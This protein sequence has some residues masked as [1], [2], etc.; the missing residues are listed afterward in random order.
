MSRGAGGW[1]G[2]AEPRPRF[3]E[4]ELSQRRP[5]AGVG[6]VDR[7]GRLVHDRHP[8]QV[9]H[10]RREWLAPRVAGRHAVP[11]GAPTR[12]GRAHVQR[13]DSRPPRAAGLPLGSGMV[14]RLLAIPPARRQLLMDLK[15]TLVIAPHP[16]DESIAA[17]GLLQR[18][19]AGG[20]DVH[21]IVVT[22]GDN[23]PWPLRYLKKKV[24]VTDADRAEWGALRREESRRALA[25]IGVP[26]TAATFLGFPDRL[27]T[28][29]AR[30]GD[31]RVRDSIAAA[32]EAFSP[33]LL[34]IPSAFDLH[35]DHR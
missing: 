17:G 16:D 35:P 8:G 12:P 24:R 34:V 15:R 1:N 3:H 22:D 19:I 10:H 31:A 21:V 28:R 9:R 32:I 30:R 23:N 26:S 33:S 11:R 2:V 20:G 13:R 5:A 6:A 27:L 7:R 4:R 14:A 29:M 18:A 25:T